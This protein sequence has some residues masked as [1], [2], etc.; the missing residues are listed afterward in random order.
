MELKRGFE[1][2]EVDAGGDSLHVDLTTCLFP[3]GITPGVADVFGVVDVL[4][5]VDEVFH[6]SPLP[7]LDHTGVY[8]ATPLLYI[9]QSVV[10]VA[11]NIVSTRL[12]LA[13]GISILLSCLC[14]KLGL[15]NPLS[16]GP[17]TRGFFH[18]HWAHNPLGW[19]ISMDLCL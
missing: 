6:V 5:I 11:C 15:R 17:P 10:A 14:S 3:I 18:L 16:R 1:N 7:S 19:A 13:S 12:Y 9:F 2:E 8:I 4:Y